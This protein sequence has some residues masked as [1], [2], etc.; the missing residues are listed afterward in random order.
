MEKQL[1]TNGKSFRRTDGKWQGTVWYLNEYGE[2]KRKS[3]SGN[4]QRIVNKKMKDYVQEFNLQK[5]T[6]KE[7]N[8]PLKESLNAYLKLFKFPTVERPT[9]DRCESIAKNQINP[10]L[11][12]KAVGDMT[13]ADIRKLLNDLMK[14][15]Y[16]YSTVKQSY[17]LLNEFYRYLE[18]EEIIQKNPMRSVSMLKK[19]NFLSAQGKDVK[20]KCDEVEILTPEEIDTLRE[21]AFSTFTDGKRKYQQPAAYFLMLNTGLRTGEILGLSNSD[22][23]LNNKVLYVRKSV[24]EVY[25]RDG[26]ERT[27]GEEI[28]VGKPKSASSKRMIPL[29]RTAIEMIEDLR[30]ERYFG[31]DSPLIADE[32]GNITKPSNF[33][34][35]YLRIL[36]AC[37]IKEKSKKRGLVITQPKEEQQGKVFTV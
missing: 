24:K 14:E 5:D 37:G 29:N 18:R 9:Y 31:E 27:S 21:E 32:N 15:G 7:A 33:R 28:V 2:R 19:A 26:S 34:K 20:A 30:N 22:I 11:G 35:R 36:E 10:K 8:L 6:N 13:A 23:D 12:K 1:L 25:K 16:S 17:N 4:T 3:F